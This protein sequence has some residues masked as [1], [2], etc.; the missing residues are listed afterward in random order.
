[1]AEIQLEAL[2]G[3]RMGQYSI[4]INLQWRICPRWGTTGRTT[5][6]S[7]TTTDEEV[8]HGC[9]ERNEAGAPRGDTG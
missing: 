7:W 5:W 6:K 4:R 9:E 3:D 2:S 8:G 1:M